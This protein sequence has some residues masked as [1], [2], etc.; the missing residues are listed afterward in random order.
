MTVGVHQGPDRTDLV[1]RYDF[2]NNSSFDSRQNW[3]LYSEQMDNAS[4]TAANTAVVANAGIAPDGTLTA[5]KI[6]ETA[7][8]PSPH[9]I[10]QTNFAAVGGAWP[11]TFSVYLKAGERSRLNIDM[12]NLVD[13]DNAANIDLIAGTISGPAS[14]GTWN[15][16]SSSIVG[17]GNG[18]YRAS[19]T[20]ITPSGY[21][22][23]RIFI[24]PSSDQSPYTGTAGSGLYMWG[25]QLVKSTD[26]LNY[27]QTTA[28]A[29]NTSITTVNN[30]QTPGTY[31][32]TLNGGMYYRR[33]TN[34][35]TN[36]VNFGALHFRNTYTD[37]ITAYTIPASLWQ[38]TW[39]VSTW[40]YFDS[41][42]GDN[43]I[44]GHGSTVVRQGLHCGVRSNRIFFGFYSDDWLGNT[45]LSNGRW[46]NLTWSYDNRTGTRKM[47]VDGVLDTTYVNAASVY[48]GTGTNTEF[49]RYPWSIFYNMAGRLADIQVYS[50]VLPDAQIV[51]NVALT[52]GRY[53]I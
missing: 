52:R 39:T 23:P 1:I 18:W 25:A 9:Y 29:V 34:T 27:A 50:S 48:A 43:A 44:F 31:N 12:S 19:I 46:Y 26:P 38:G 51:S 17:V 8:G 20:G 45:V 53:G 3:L 7:T 2:N 37:F 33:A 21:P 22:G 47:Y 36:D 5:D 40:A 30:L 49:G 10:F 16:L 11:W 15:T 28:A 35:Q 4:W 24:F 14:S 41:L 32:G 6:N 13:G 42:A